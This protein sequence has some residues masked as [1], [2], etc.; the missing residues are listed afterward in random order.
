[1]RKLLCPGRY[2][3]STL[4]WSHNGR[5]GVSNHQTHGCLLNRLFRCRSKKIS[6]LRGTGR[7]AGNS[8][9][10]GHILPVN[11][12][13]LWIYLLI[14]IGLIKLDT[15]AFILCTNQILWES[16]CWILSISQMNK[17]ISSPCVLTSSKFYN[18]S[19]KQTEYSSCVKST[20]RIYKQHETSSEDQSVAIWVFVDY[21]NDN[22]LLWAYTTTTNLK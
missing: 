3:D 16:E 18:T 6:K 1:M 15:A 21:E 9:V 14:Y 12:N 20:K 2:Q 10:T 13:T 17:N 19:V 4:L 11:D 8:P 7:C 5:D 22:A